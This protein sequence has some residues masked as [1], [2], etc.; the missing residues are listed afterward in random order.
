MVEKYSEQHAVC[1]MKFAY[2]NLNRMKLLLTAAGGTRHENFVHDLV[3]M[4]IESTRRFMQV[5]EEA[6]LPVA[7]L[8]PHFEHTIT[9]GMYNSFFE[10]I[11]HDVPY[12]EAMECSMKI[13][14]FYQA[15]WSACMGLK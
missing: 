14:K 12:D 4:E 3:E 15:G 5:M 8:N 1:G 13:Y 7:R 11:I 6:R 9:S 10:L 2:E